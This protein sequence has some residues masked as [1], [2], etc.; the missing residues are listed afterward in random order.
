METAL[1]K[2][3][4]DGDLER[5]KCNYDK[6]V[7]L[8]QKALEQSSKEDSSGDS[9]TKAALLNKIAECLIPLGRW[10]EAEERYQIV[11]EQFGKTDPQ[12]EKTLQAWAG[13]GKVFLLKGSFQYSI[14][15]FQ[16]VLHLAKQINNEKEKALSYYFLGT[17]Y[18]KMGE[19][20]E[21]S[22]MLSKALELLEGAS[23]GVNDPALLA[24][25]Y[26]EKAIPFLREHSLENSLKMLDK[27][28]SL[29]EKIP[30]A[31]ERAEAFRFKGIVLYENGDYA[32]AVSNFIESLNI[33]RKL[34]HPYGEPGVYNSLGQ[35]FLSLIK[36]EIALVFLEKGVQ[37]CQRMKFTPELAAI[38]GKLGDAYMLMENYE[39]AINYYQ[40]DL[41]L[42]GN[43]ESSRARAYTNHNLG[44]CYISIG[45]VTEGLSYLKKSLD[46]FRQV[47]DE[48]NVAKV[49]RDKCFAYISLGTLEESERI[50][51]EAIKIFSAFNKASEE[52]YTKIL[53]G[54]IERH[55]TNWDK[56]EQF[57]TESL[58]VLEK[59]DSPYFLSEAYYEYALLNLAKQD[60]EKALDNFEEAL[61]ITRKL[62][63]KE[64]MVRNLKII[65]RIDSLRLLKILEKEL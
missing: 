50:G 35:L 16:N 7:F 10:D 57:F 3:I 63:L 8:Y 24:A 22:V 19:N 40:K 29:T 20:E 58:K 1:E 13:K 45:K 56:A 2:T 44:K 11:L 12:D 38:Y 32:K 43:S 37:I 51:Q 47:G 60:I 46:L 30:F 48:L 54:S 36:P 65:E 55:R 53:L 27:S 14:T 25:V 5:D 9:K 49:C 18:G 23:A 39:T 64:Q 34:N 41:E 52:A 17:L 59:E 21:S 4:K 61:K 28:L 62:Q 26:N 6:A 15:Y 33:Y 42:S 31:I